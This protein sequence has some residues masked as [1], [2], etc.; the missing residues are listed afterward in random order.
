[1][2]SSMKTPPKPSRGRHAPRNLMRIFNEQNAAAAQILEARN[3]S[4]KFL[5]DWAKA[6][7]RCRAQEVAARK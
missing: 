7:Q 4:P 6:F 2:G 5:T 1:M 3:Q